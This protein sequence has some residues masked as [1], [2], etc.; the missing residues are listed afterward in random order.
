MKTSLF[1]TFMFGVL[2]AA[3]TAP[4]LAADHSR[5]GE[6]KLSQAGACKASCKANA[7]SCRAQCSDPEERANC[8]YECDTCMANCEKFED[9]CKQHCPSSS[10]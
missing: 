3:S 5:L 6:F 10:G 8:L 9:A 2:L 1:T 7:N 4:S